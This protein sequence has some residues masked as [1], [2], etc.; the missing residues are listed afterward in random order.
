MTE[1][2]LVKY[3]EVQKEWS[4]IVFGEGPRTGGLIDHI[5]D[6]LKEIEADPLDVMEWVDVAILALDGAW[7]AGFSPEEVAKAM[8]AKQLVNIRRK[9]HVPES[10]NKRVEHIEEPR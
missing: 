2:D 9:W 3:L 4:E 1:I 10:E 5:K 6:E 7:R 8:D